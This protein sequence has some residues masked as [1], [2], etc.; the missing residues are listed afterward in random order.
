MLAVAGIVSIPLEYLVFTLITNETV[1]NC[2]SVVVICLLILTAVFLIYRIKRFRSGLSFQSNDGSIELLLLISILSVFLFTLFYT[3]NVSSSPF[4]IIILSIIFCGLGFIVLWKKHVTNSYTKMIY[5]RNEDLYAQRIEEYEK[6]R[7]ELLNQS[8]ELSKIIH[9]DNKLIPALAEAVQKLIAASPDKKDYKDLLVQIEKLSAERKEVINDYQAKSDT[10]PKTN[11]T[12]LDAVIHF[13]H[14]KALQN[15]IS[16]EFI[17]EAEAIP[18]L[19]DCVKDHTDLNTVLCDLGENAIIATKNISGGKIR[20]AFE[21]DGANAPSISFYDNGAKFDEKV[22]ANMGKKRI[23]TH[24]SEGGSGIGLMT[25]FEILHKYNAS[26]C[27][28]ERSDNGEYTKQ[29]K[30]SFDNLHNISILNARE[31]I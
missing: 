12:A 14:N 7:G 6:E 31:N 15:G 29:I 22:L 13:L 25:L 17:V 16:A 5:K 30:I 24:K 28:D 20:I 21:V 8:A 19:L 11:N 10:L 18:P 1:R 23:T 4:E 3:S 27:L 26:Y 2:V 9:R